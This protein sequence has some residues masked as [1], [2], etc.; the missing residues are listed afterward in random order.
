LPLFFDIGANR[1]DATVAA[2]AQGYDVI[3]VEPS[4]IY[5]DLVKNFI[6]EPR[7]IP[8]KFAVSDTDNER[9]EFYEAEEDGLSTLNKEWLT[10]E[11]MPYAGKPF[12]T[13]HA[14]TITIDTLAKIYGEPDLI[15]IDVE[16]GEWS[17]FRGTTRKMGMITFEWTYNTIAEHAKQLDHLKALGYSKCSIR[18][19]EDHLQLPPE[20]S[21]LS[22]DIADSLQEQ[23]DTR[24]P[25]WESNE[26]KT[27]GLRPTAD[28]GMC[29]VR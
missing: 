8:I 12:R 5:A 17:V 21:W 9:V 15:K 19:I 16:G 29:W 3:A 1:G 18:F 2:L 27:A 22:L 14:N 24:A 7:V 23:I 28:V 6:Y 11:T 4:R 13:I 25:A 20:D 26:W 10:S